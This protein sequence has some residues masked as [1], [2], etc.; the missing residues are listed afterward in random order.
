[1]L[2]VLTG[3]PSR[4]LFIPYFMDETV[5]YDSWY[6]LVALLVLEAYM[7]VRTGGAK[8]DHVNHLAGLAAGVVFGRILRPKEESKPILHAE[9]TASITAKE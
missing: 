2:D 6:A 8:Y 1:M 3:I 5:T 7:V 9:Y 4:D